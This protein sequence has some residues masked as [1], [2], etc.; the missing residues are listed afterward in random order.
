MNL[1]F[2][3]GR[4][5]AW[6]VIVVV[7]AWGYLCSLQTGNDGLWFQPDSSRHAL[8]GLFWKDFLQT[9]PADPRA[10]ALGYFARYPAIN[11]IS[12]PPFFYLLEGALFAAFGP[13]PYLAKGLV[14]SFTLLG[15]IYTLAWLRRWVAE[16]AGF[17]AAVVPLLPGIAEWSHAIM[18]NVPACALTWAAL[19]HTRCWIE[20][21]RPRHLYLAAVFSALAVLTYFQSAIVVPIIVAWLVAAGRLRL[22]A[23]PRTLAIASVCGVV[24][25]PCLIVVTRWAP[26]HVEMTTPSLRLLSHSDA[27]LFYLAAAPA[28]FGLPL[29]ALAAAGVIAGAAVRRWRFETTI[30]LI[31]VIFTYMFLSYLKAKDTRY[32]LPLAVPLVLLGSIGLVA[33]AGV[34]ARLCGPRWGAAVVVAAASFLMMLGWQA[35]RMP[36]HTQRGFYE[37]ADWLGTVAPDEPVLYD[38]Y[39]HGA[40]T[41]HVRAADPDRRRMVVRGDKLLYVISLN[42]KSIDFRDF[43][44]SPQEVIE[45]LKTRSGC[46]WLAIERGLERPPNLAYQYLREAVKDPLFQHVASVPIV[47][48]QSTDCIDLYCMQTSVKQQDEIDL[49]VPLWGKDSR[50]NVRPIARSHLTSSIFSQATRARS[51][52]KNQP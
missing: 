50:V 14:L 37:L 5:L 6:Q 21:L 13:S 42:N 45:V 22:L 10:F 28:L 26:M 27:W 51:L 4:N 36:S 23:A 43:A 20:E 40:F 24:L 29:L 49:P 32:L 34:L 48:A 16:E 15:A 33:M 1:N 8:N 46:R 17:L 7:I 38:G 52:S 2:R 19:F 9:L 12:Y 44:T 47:G 30:L 41:F 39:S 11:P 31:W 35:W 3:P 25:L 18:L